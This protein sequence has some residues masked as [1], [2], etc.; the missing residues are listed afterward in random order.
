MFLI[1]MYSLVE[2]ESEAQNVKSTSDKVQ[3]T[4]DET[5]EST[6]L[7]LNKPNVKDR[8]HPLQWIFITV[9]YTIVVSTGV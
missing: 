5:V 3:D 6:D 1:I 9:P 8:E 2:V 4:I 7:D